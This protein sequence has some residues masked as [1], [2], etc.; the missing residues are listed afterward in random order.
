MEKILLSAEQYEKFVA[1]LNRPVQLKPRLG[2]LM[3]EPSI[4]EEKEKGK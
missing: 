2:R 3:N 1:M 4:L